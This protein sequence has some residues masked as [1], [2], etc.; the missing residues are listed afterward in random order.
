M[1]K[2]WPTRLNGSEKWSSFFAKRAFFCK[3]TPQFPAPRVAKKGDQMALFV[4]IYRPD[5]KMKDPT[6][7]SQK[8]KSEKQ[9]ALLGM[10]NVTLMTINV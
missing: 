3:Q 7:F 8:L 5:H 6:L 2:V 1:K 9:I 4:V 10:E